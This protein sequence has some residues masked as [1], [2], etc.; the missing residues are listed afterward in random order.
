MHICNGICNLFD[1]AKGCKKL[2]NLISGHEGKHQCEISEINHICKGVCFLKGKTL[3]KCYNTCCLSYGH[4]GDCICKKEIEHI[5]DKECSLFNKAQHCKQYCHKPD[6]HSDKH[7]CEVKKHICPNQC[8]YFGK[9]KGNCDKLCNKEY[10][11]N[12]IC[13]CNIMDNVNYHLCNKICEY[14]GQSRGCN[15]ECIK[16]Y[17]H[18]D[19][20]QCSANDAS[21]FCKRKCELCENECG[22]FLI[23]IIMIK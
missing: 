19:N 4:N 2:C 6:G 8:Y 23:M 20:C 17:G 9:C 3:G 16:K 11:H 14:Y 21:H 13:S 5:C 15:K 22:H 7:L 18:E 12:D 1:H 10:G